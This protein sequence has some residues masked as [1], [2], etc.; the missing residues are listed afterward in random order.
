MILYDGSTQQ[1]LCRSY[2]QLPEEIN[3]LSHGTVINFE[4]LSLCTF[5]NLCKFHVSP[6][7]NKHKKPFSF[8]SGNYYMHQKNYAC[9]NV[10]G[11]LS[12]CTK[13]KNLLSNH[14]DWITF[15]DQPAGFS[16]G[17][18]V[19]SLCKYHS[20]L[21]MKCVSIL[22]LHLLCARHFVNS[23]SPNLF[24]MLSFQASTTL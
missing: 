11:N 4:F 6:I 18:A 9:E 5:L 19:N 10:S 21:L 13:R 12:C 1:L 15:Q 23:N 20:F 16:D 22:I 3:G 14:G 24:R 2:L 8:I 17:Q 7:K